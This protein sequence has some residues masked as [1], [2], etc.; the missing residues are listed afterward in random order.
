M[1]AIGSLVEEMVIGIGSV[2]SLVVV[3]GMSRE[4]CKG[5]GSTY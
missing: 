4:N 5:S 1:S 3:A 2:M